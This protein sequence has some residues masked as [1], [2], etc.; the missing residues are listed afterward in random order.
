MSSARECGPHLVV[1]AVH[2]LAHPE[3]VF[4]DQDEKALLLLLTPRAAD[5]ADSPTQR[6]ESIPRPV[7][8]VHLLLQLI[9]HDR[10]CMSSS[11][12]RRRY[13]QR[14]GQRTIGAGRHC[15]TGVFGVKMRQVDERVAHRL[16]HGDGIRVFCLL[17]NDFTAL[18]L[19]NEHLRRAE[20]NAYTGSVDDSTGL[21]LTSS[22]FAM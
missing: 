20:R 9:Q 22:G 19:F 8:V 12:S 21:G 13:Q 14:A 18:V 4:D 2:G 7:G 6:V 3:K 10:L 1:L 11:M 15:R 5:G 17:S 16:I